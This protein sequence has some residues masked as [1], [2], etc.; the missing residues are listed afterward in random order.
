MS[1]LRALFRN[2]QGFRVAFEENGVQEVTDPDGFTWVLQDL[3][4]LYEVGLPMLPPRQRQAIELC[5]V[6]NKRECDAAVAMGV[7][8]T[9]PV[10]MYAGDGLRNLLKIIEAGDLPRFRINSPSQEVA[11]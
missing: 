11:G 10:A 9:N 8:P 3:E 7:S 4:Y 2:L 1:T 6:Q 5:L